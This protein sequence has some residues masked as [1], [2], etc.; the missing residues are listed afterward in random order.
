MS[1]KNNAEV[2]IGGKIYQLSG[3]ESEEYLQKVA[4]YINAKRAEIDEIEGNRRMPADMKATLVELNLADDYFKAKKTAENLET[5]I[6]EKEKN[7]YELRHDLVSVQMEKDDLKKQIE[8]I[9]KEK[10]K[11]S[12]DNATLKERLSSAKKTGNK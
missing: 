3:F 11:L 10:E 5:D 2:L 12:I 4:A 8:Q 9:K 6:Q 7:L 1:T